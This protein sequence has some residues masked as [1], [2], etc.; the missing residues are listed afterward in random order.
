MGAEPGLT[1]ENGA[2]PGSGRGERDGTLEENPQQKGFVTHFSAT[3]ECGGIKRVPG[4]ATA[5]L[6]LP[7]GARE[8]E[9]S[10]GDGGARPWKSRKIIV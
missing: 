4:I 5:A 2:F 8:G 9:F 7:L 1:F 6:F 10:S 3:G